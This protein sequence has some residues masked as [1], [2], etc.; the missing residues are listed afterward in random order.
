MQ[1]LPAARRQWVPA[2]PGLV[3]ALKEDNFWIKKAATIALINIK[4]NVSEH[5]VELLKSD[6]KEWRQAGL[7]VLKEIHIDTLER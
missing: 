4:E 6:N 1:L 5:L 7:A 3:S 2:I